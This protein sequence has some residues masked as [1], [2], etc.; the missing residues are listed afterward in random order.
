MSPNDSWWARQ[1]VES[2]K[3]FIR[4]YNRFCVIREIED[5]NIADRLH[6]ELNEAYKLSLNFLDYIEFARAYM[7]G[8]GYVV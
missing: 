1:F 4:V 8:R 7:I 3:E 2:L 6:E 5:F